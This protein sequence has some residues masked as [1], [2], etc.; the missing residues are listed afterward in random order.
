MKAMVAA[1]LLVGQSLPV[2]ADENDDLAAVAAIVPG[3][4]FKE[5]W[6]WTISSRAG[7]THVMKSVDG[8]SVTTPKQTFYLIRRGDGFAIAPGKKGVRLLS[9]PE[10]ADLLQRK[11]R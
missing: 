10:V 2:L 8:Y 7:N 1:L 11:R 3:S 4:I 9:P 5:S 6:G